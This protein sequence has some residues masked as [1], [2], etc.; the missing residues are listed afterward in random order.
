MKSG[1]TKNATIHDIL[2]LNKTVINLIIFEYIILMPETDRDD[3][4]NAK[5]NRKRKY[6]EK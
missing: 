5:D 3:R 4:E 6:F 2:Y 1:G